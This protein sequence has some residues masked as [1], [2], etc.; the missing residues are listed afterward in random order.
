[1]KFLLSATKLRRLCFYT[2]LPVILF[3][4]GGSASVHVGIQPPVPPLGADTPGTRHPLGPGTLP[5]TRHPSGTRHHPLPADGY[6]CGRYASYWN[7]FLFSHNFLPKQE[8]KNVLIDKH[9]KTN[10]T[11][12]RSE[13]SW[14]SV[15]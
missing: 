15:F 2:C 4:G 8:L 7:A 12:V 1:M 14:C 6:C 10:Y 11:P 5:R 9:Y 3:T 13:C